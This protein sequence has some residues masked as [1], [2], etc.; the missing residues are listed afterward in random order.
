MHCSKSSIVLLETAR[1]LI[2]FTDKEKI[3]AAEN[4]KE[5]CQGL[6]W[7]L[8]KDISEPP[9]VPIGHLDNEMYW[10][11]NEDMLDAYLIWKARK[12]RGEETICENF[13]S[14]KKI[15]KFQ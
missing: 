14:G 1:Y 8:E 15:E 3:E 7:T 4:V 2:N 5:R 11:D 13:A 10:L 9:K 6:G 12:G